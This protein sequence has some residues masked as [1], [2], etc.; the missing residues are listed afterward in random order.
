M[1]D[2]DQRLKVVLKKCFEEFFEL[3]L[4]EANRFD[5]SRVEWLEQEVFPDP[6]AGRR[7]VLDLVAKMP[8][9]S[10]EADLPEEPDEWLSLV[11]VE[12]ESGDSVTRLRRYMFRS[13]A[14]LRDRYDLPVLPV[15]VYLRVGLEGL[16]TEQYQE[17]YGSLDVLTFKYHYVGLP[18]LDALEY[19]QKN[20]LGAALSSLMGTP[21]ERRASV[22]VTAAKQIAKLPEDDERRF[23]LAELLSA[24]IDFSPDE[25]QE[26]E[27][28]L[29][30]DENREAR[31]M[32]ATFFEQ[33]L[34]R[35]LEQ[36]QRKVVLALLED[37]FNS[38]NPET[39]E[40]V[41]QWPA[42]DLTEL[43]RRIPHAKSLS[44]LGLEPQS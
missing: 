41:R 27:H 42:D 22:V 29:Q 44:E 19:L 23:L 31:E 12:I 35:G 4:P 28:L 43:A 32:S 34:E 6:P 13:Y 5:F 7:R 21:K 26:F 37:R 17:F 20:D 15:A 16:G 14:N 8:V 3:F 11:H 10:G 18:K 1:V 36:G 24:Y 30:L 39:V 2:H 33:G 25:K 9:R 40:R 38:L